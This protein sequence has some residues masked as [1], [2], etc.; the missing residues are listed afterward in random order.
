VPQHRL[1]QLGNIVQGVKAI[2]IDVENFE[3]FVFKGA[4]NTLRKYKPLIYCELWDN[5]NRAQCFELLSGELGYK[6]MVLE[7]GKLVKFDPGV[8]E[9]QNFFFVGDTV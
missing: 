8:H 9:N 4:E 6:I 2:K 7:E 5:E 3:Y 1:D